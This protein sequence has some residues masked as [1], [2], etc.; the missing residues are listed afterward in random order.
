[1]RHTI[2]LCA[3]LLLSTFLAEAGTIDLTVD[4]P[5]GVERGGWPVTSG[6][7]L[8]EGAANQCVADNF[9]GFQS[10]RIE[11]VDGT[12]VF[13]S[14]RGMQEALDYVKTGK[15]PAIV[16]ADCVRMFSHSNSD[17]QELYRDQAEVNE[18]RRSDPVA[19]F[20][21]Y[22]LDN[23]E[24]AEEEIL[25]LEDE[26]TAAVEEAS[27]RVEEEPEP[28]PSTALNFIIPPGYGDAENETREDAPLGEPA[29]HGCDVLN[30]RR[31]ESLRDFCGGLACRTYDDER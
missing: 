9:K 18:A 3:A 24:L 15:G 10:V 16:H 29:V 25:R 17:R 2:F 31:F 23:G 8:R 12:N 21:A 22:L 26:N 5:S 19:R 11:R 7:P 27:A 14:W 1:M 30:A 4:E 6:V 13:D 20:R 28:D